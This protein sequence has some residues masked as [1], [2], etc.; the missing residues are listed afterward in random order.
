[1]RKL[2]LISIVLFGFVNSSIAQKTITGKVTDDQQNP[3]AGVTIL[4]KGT[5]V[6]GMVVGT[7]TDA[8]GVFSF[9]V[10]ISLFSYMMIWE[11]FCAPTQ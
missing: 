7:L 4:V 2:L 8:D 3:L 10:P 5:M 6:K 11:G 9:P 1:M